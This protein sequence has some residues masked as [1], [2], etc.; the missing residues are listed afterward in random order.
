[1]LH[2][3]HPDP[4]SPDAPADDAGPVTPIGPERLRAL[5]EAILSGTYPLDA[6]VTHGLANLFS[7]GAPRAAAAA[8]PPE[9]GATS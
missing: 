8:R 7:E 4:L 9:P 1:L 3:P 5:R 2:V 6:A